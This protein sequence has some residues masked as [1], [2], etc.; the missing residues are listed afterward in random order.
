MA[1]SMVTVRSTDGKSFG[2]YLAGDDKQSAPGVI[3]LQEIFGLNPFVRGACDQ[4]ASA[5]FVAIAPDL[6]WRQQ[7]DVQLDSETQ[8]DREHGTR[9]MR[10]LDERLAI[11]DATA[12]LAH[13]RSLSQCTGKVG[14]VGYCLGGKLAYLMAEQTNIDVAVSYYGVGIHSVLSERAIFRAPLMLHIATEDHLC[15]PQAQAEITRVLGGVQGVT[16]QFHKGA[17]H[18]FARKGSA[19]YS[20]EAAKSADSQTMAFLKM[21]LSHSEGKLADP[22]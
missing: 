10:G 18:A 15:P 2:A 14:A 1:G 16:L 22:D 13:L 20:V 17:K 21:C 11:E 7:P 5:G 12:A 6:F 4:F 3:V 19:M 8:V 9:L